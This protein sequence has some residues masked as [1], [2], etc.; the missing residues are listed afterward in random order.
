MF[1]NDCCEVFPFLVASLV[2][3]NVFGLVF[4]GIEAA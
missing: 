4:G 2:G 3:V 1:G